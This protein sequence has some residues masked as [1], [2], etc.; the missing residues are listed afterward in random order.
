MSFRKSWSASV[1]IS[2]SAGS[3]SASGSASS[4]V[5][6]AICASSSAA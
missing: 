6:T 2:V 5:T 1:V 3:I 4:A